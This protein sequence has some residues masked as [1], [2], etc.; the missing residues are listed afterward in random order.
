MCVICDPFPTASTLRAKSIQQTHTESQLS[1]TAGTCLLHVVYSS[2][3]PMVGAQCA[4]MGCRGEGSEKVHH[5]VES[6][7]A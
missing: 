7:V 6:G 5:Q 1:E 2:I 3:S 4:C